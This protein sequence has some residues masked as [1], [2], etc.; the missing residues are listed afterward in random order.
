MSIESL[1]SQYLNELKRLLAQA[2]Q[3]G[4][5]TPELSFRPALDKFF[6]ALPKTLSIQQVEV[7][8]EPKQQYRA[9]RPDWKFLHSKTFGIFGYVEAKGINLEQ[10]LDPE[11]YREQI[12][13]YLGLG[14]RVILTDGLEFLFFDPESSKGIRLGLTKKPLTMGA[15]WPILPDPRILTKF[16][17][18]LQT[19][20]AREVS[21]RV[22]MLDL[23]KRTRLIAEDIEELVNTPAG[24]GQDTKEN[25]TIA[26]LSSL[27]D[28]LSSSHDPDLLGNDRFA[29]MV[30][31]VLI[32]SLMYAH[33]YVAPGEN[34]PK[35]VADKLRTFW[36]SA[37]SSDGINRLRPFRA[38]AAITQ[39]D[40]ASLGRLNTW[41]L[42]SIEYLAHVRLD[43]T[44]A[45]STNYHKLYEEYF[46][47]LDP[48][49]KIDWGA[50]A[51]HPSLARFVVS[52]CD[53]VAGEQ[54]G[55]SSLFLEPNKII[56]PCCGTGVF[57]EK[58]AELSP[59][60]MV[61][62]VVGFE[63]QPAPYALSQ[64]RMSLIASEGILSALDVNVIL[65]NSLSDAIVKAE[66]PELDTAVPDQ[67]KMFEQE[68][69]EA[70]NLAKPP[71]TVVLGN[72]PSSDAGLHGDAAIYSKILS[73]LDEFRPP[74]EERGARQN[75]QKQI[76]ND[77]MK[78]LRWGLYKLPA[79]KPAILAF[80][81][82][83]SFLG[84][85]T[86]SV[87]RKWI[88]D[89]FS[90]VWAIEFDA[91]LRA[92]TMSSQLFETRQGRCLLICARIT[93]PATTTTI[94]Y[95]SLLK[96]DRI[97]KEQF[98][99]QAA[100]SLTTG[101]AIASIKFEQ[102]DVAELPYRF[103]PQKSFDQERY[104]SFYRLCPR[105]QDATETEKVIFLRHVS[106]IKLGVTAAFV[107]KDKKLLSRKILEL[108]SRSYPELRENWFK[109]QQ[110]PPREETLNPSVLASVGAKTKGSRH[111]DN[112]RRYS[113]RPSVEM[114]AYLDPQL[115]KELADEG[116]GGTRYRPELFAS[117][118]R[119]GNFGIS[120][121]PAPENIG[122]S[123]HRF[124][125]VSWNIPDNDLCSRGNAH[126]FCPY[127]PAYKKRT[128][129]EW[130]PTP[131]LNIS[132]ELMSYYADAA[133]NEEGTAALIALYTHAVLSSGCY[134]QTFEG[135]L[136]TTSGEWPRVPFPTDREL[137]FSLA[138]L[139]SALADLE[140]DNDLEVQ[141]NETELFRIQSFSEVEF[142]LTDFEINAED[143]TLILAA[144]DQRYT[145]AG[146]DIEAVSAS[147]SGHVPLR[148]WLKWHKRPY[149]NRKFNFDD[150]QRLSA[151]LT[152]LEVQLKVLKEI[153]YFVSA[154]LDETQ[155]ELI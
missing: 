26:A 94:K 136:Y 12:E 141:L 33:R 116:G 83:G 18:F 127:F 14:H 80:V 140:R 5:S 45:Q 43:W 30:A 59:K 73:L 155:T 92:G 89:H 15:E 118:K 51:T 145:I 74:E 149:L 76:G 13:R 25:D 104:A 38:L 88:A 1:V 79:D 22:L 109:G 40:P 142:W 34:D 97:D 48:Q 146:I 27:R 21:D 117:Y 126:V 96:L 110:K 49:A 150:A 75:I 93:E 23:A 103:K 3:F 16:N 139:G 119:G 53:S 62:N 42:D 58:C 143:K 2:R 60:K 115:L 154:L 17:E 28:A 95:K 46:T 98:F 134:L 31:Q 61:A 55:S 4:D 85:G 91:D 86:Y 128:K 78:F 123:L 41:Y 67:L 11:A 19:P 133:S 129:D 7:I 138:K 68:R 9:G 35:V 24:A 56:D 69:A 64:L 54:F 66:L 8:Y 135:A 105:K 131:K 39:S 87:A 37:I 84:H 77:F 108:G 47:A 122:D 111:V 71:V 147:V 124:S 151:L 50:Y 120:V 114:Y 100:E 112:I 130:N 81:V 132:T 63:I 113:F 152:R 125:A 148:E 153:D 52:F 65:C 82:P 36:T 102:I 72:P 44:G 57:L 6:R 101:T 121:A 20:S 70:I 144:D 99:E 32:F 10:E 90:E 107:H 137:F 106:G 29:D